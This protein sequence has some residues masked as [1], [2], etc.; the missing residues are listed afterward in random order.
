M[1]ESRYKT[2]T[3]INKHVGKFAWGTPS[4]VSNE[5]LRQV[6]FLVDKNGQRH[7]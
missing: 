6:V 5:I 7:F 2:K 3:F 1:G 4:N